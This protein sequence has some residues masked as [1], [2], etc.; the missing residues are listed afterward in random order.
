MWRVK[1][2]HTSVHCDSPITFLLMP[3]ALRAL[4]K[5]GQLQ[6]ILNT[7]NIIRSVFFTRSLIHTAAEMTFFFSQSRVKSPKRVSLEHGLM[8][9]ANRL[10]PLGHELI[11]SKTWGQIRVLWW[12]RRWA[13]LDC[14][15]RQKRDKNK[16]GSEYTVVVAER[17]RWTKKKKSLWGGLGGLFPPHWAVILYVYCRCTLEK[18]VVCLLSTQPHCPRA[19]RQCNMFKCEGQECASFFMRRRIYMW[20]PWK[21]TDHLVNISFFIYSFFV[22]L[23]W[24]CFKKTIWN[25][26]TWFMFNWIKWILVSA[27][28]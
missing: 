25:I 28:S 15:L 12:E 2:T 4:Q 13:W 21:T 17:G 6:H 18:S 22:A 24:W 7:A 3:W 14:T 5:P 20:Q 23:M 10:I 27:M 9:E 19:L 11:K 1:V 16:E 8:Q 26:S